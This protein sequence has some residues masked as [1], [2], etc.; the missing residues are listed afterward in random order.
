MPLPLD[1]LVATP[2]LVNQRAQDLSWTDLLFEYELALDDDVALLG[3]LSEKQLHFKPA[4][5]V[6]SIAEVLTHNCHNDQL[7]WNWVRLLA[8]GRRS[9]I[10]PKDLS[11]GDGAQNDRS[12]DALSSLIEACRALARTTIDLLPDPSDLTSTA[13]HPYFGKLNAK[14]WIYFMCLHHGMH[15]CQAEQVIDTPNFPPGDSASVSSRA[16]DRYA[17]LPARR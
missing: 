1:E 10:N 13:P 16:G 8:N 5:E 14:G 2:E 4:T 15:L 12:L 7:V 6:F 17:G 11:G 9:E 3:G